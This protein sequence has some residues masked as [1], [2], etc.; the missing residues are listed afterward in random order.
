MTTTAKKTKARGLVAGKAPKRS[1]K[2]N[3]PERPTELQT[4]PPS[5]ESVM[6]NGRAT[7]VE[8]SRSRPKA[9][10][11]LG[12]VLGMLEDPAGVTLAHLAEVTGWLPHT[13]RAAL[14]GLRKRGFRI[15]LQPS[16]EGTGS[17]YRIS[18]DAA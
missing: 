2:A 8:W 18:T 5:A 13:T 12:I 3:R 6:D 9:S 14:T 17:M 11:K 7:A 1:S 10:S 16:A 4:V 15:E